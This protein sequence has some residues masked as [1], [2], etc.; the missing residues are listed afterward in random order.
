MWCLAAW[1]AHA[2]GAEPPDPTRRPVSLATQLKHGLQVRAGDFGGVHLERVVLYPE[3]VKLSERKLEQKLNGDEWLPIGVIETRDHGR[4]RLACH[5]DRCLATSIT[6]ISI[7]LQLLKEMP[8]G[9][10]ERRRP[11]SRR[12]ES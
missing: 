12:S 9:L 4:L 7:E 3:V 1:L 11:R 2:E 6:G 5:Q 10:P 8:E